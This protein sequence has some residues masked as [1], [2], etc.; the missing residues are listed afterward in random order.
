VG[1]EGLD[2]HEGQDIVLRDQPAE[3]AQSVVGLLQDGEAQRRL[4]QAARALAEK[5]GWPFIGASFG[6]ILERVTR[7]SSHVVPQ[8]SPGQD[9]DDSPQTS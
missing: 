1:A 9:L 6:E 5:Y 2:V 4:G 3:F 8:Y 7:Q